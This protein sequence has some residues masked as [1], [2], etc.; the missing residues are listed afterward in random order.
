MD[1]KTHWEGVYA[2]RQPTE[3][4]WYQPLP[5]RSR[6]LIEEAGARP[7]TRIID[8]GGGDSTLVDALLERGVG[9]VTVLDLF[10]AEP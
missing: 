5:A 8:V 6:E 7:E 3:V 9:R 4:S 2:T 1:R 10:G